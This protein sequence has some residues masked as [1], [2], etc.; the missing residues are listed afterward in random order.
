MEAFTL[1]S[2]SIRVMFSILTQL[3]EYLGILHHSTSALS[4]GQELVL[5]CSLPKYSINCVNMLDITRIP[6]LRSV[7]A[8]ARP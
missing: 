8:S 1:L 6:M 7:I 4:Q 2:V 5:W 3:I